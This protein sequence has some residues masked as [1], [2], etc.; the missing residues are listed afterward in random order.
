MFESRE[1]G[2]RHRVTRAAFTLISNF[3]IWFVIGNYVASLFTQSVPTTP[4]T[5]SLVLTYGIVI[6]ALQT[7]GSLTEGMGLSVPF[8]SGSYIASAYFTYVASSGGNLSIAYQ[9]I[10]IGISFPLL[11]FLLM[12]PSLFNVVRIPLTYLLEGSEAGKEAKDVP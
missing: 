11:L 1:I 6:T 5:T 9:G 3:L 7:L 4:F 10:R 2:W 8:N 12:L